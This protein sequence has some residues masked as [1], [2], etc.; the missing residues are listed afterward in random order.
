MNAYYSPN[1][2]TK[3]EA[4]NLINKFNQRNTGKILLKFNPAMQI[5]V[6]NLK[7]KDTTIKYVQ[8]LDK[9]NFIIPK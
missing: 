3:A 4:V 2:N 8:S 5:M 7:G 9:F 1:K 6:I